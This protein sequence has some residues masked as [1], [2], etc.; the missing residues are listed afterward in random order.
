MP[1]KVTFINQGELFEVYVRKIYPSDMFGFITLEEFDFNDSG[2]VVDPSE[3]RLKSEFENVERCYIPMHNIVRVD[4]VRKK[5]VAKITEIE[6][7]KVVKL[8]RS[9]YTDVNNS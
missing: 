6:A 4:E 8:P 1:F 5:G 2:L 7:D 3:E 9:I